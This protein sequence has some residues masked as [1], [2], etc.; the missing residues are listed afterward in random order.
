MVTVAAQK[1]T[2]QAIFWVNVVI[3]LVWWWQGSGWLLTTGGWPGFF[4]AIGRLLGL[5]AAFAILLQFIFMGRAPWLERVFGLDQL[6]RIHH[7]NGMWSFW[8]IVSHPLFLTI[9]YSLV[10]RVSLLE[11]F[12]LFIT[13]YPY[14]LWALVGLILFVIVITT[15]LFIIRQKLRYETWYF[16]HVLVY[17]AVFATFWHQITVGS[18]LITHTLFYWYWLLLY[19]VVLGNHVWWRFIRQ[20]YV[21]HRHR[22]TVS[23][24]VPETHNATSLYLTGRALS[25]FFIRPGQFMVVR[26]LTK[27]RWWQAHPFSLSQL[28]NGRELRIT[29]KAVGD[30]TR[31]INTI[32]VGTK[33]MIDGPYGIFTEQQSIRERVLLIAGGIGITPL[34]SLLEQLINKKKDVTLLYAN[35]TPNDIVFRH[36]LSTLE[37]EKNA[38][39]IHIMSADPTFSGEKGYIDAERILRLVPDVASRDIYLCGPPPM[40]KA[41]RASL[42]S[43]GVPNSQINFE[44]F[45]L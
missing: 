24:V 13:S 27:G 41:V 42:Y 22:F 8:L 35:Q 36:E 4:I 40:I 19:V 39:V 6:S 23:R 38:K 37:K 16:L 10:A 2:W 5:S 33:V 15:S 1:K 32:P 34:R 7:T 44:L 28:P 30:F 17:V 26:F 45:S 21:W 29:A 18:D 31:Q 25:A 9:G 43:L 20:I 14:A 3:I 11:Q 12:L